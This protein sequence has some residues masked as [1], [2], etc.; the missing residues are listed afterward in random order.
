M[1]IKY[2]NFF[3]PIKKRG[4]SKIFYK[5]NCAFEDTPSDIR[6][7]GIEIVYMNTLPL[8]SIIADVSAEIAEIFN[9][10]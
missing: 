4:V 3:R 6:K 1:L 9:E 10:M 7:L 8:Y 2:F 5:L